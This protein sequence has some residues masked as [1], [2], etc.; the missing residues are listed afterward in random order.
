MC[1]IVLRQPKDTSETGATW[2]LTVRWG[3]LS[4]HLVS[5][6]P[7]LR[8]AEPSWALCALTCHVAS[9]A[10]AHYTCLS[11]PLL[12]AA[13]LRALAAKVTAFIG[14]KIPFKIFKNIIHIMG[15]GIDGG[16]S[17]SSHLL[18]HA[19]HIC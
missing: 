12:C 2:L 15:E 18:S 19:D 10:T 4:A 11:P 7:A 6:Q 8:V 16:E 14:S 9:R 13:S 17:E 5:Q 1:G 3:H